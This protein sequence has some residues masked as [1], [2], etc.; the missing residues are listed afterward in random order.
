VYLALTIFAP[1]SCR[2]KSVRRS[3]RLC[4]L[5]RNSEWFRNLEQSSTVIVCTSTDP[6]LKTLAFSDQQASENISLMA[7]KLSG[8]CNSA[9]T[10]IPSE[11]NKPLSV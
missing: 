9:D 2:E 3:N 6:T 8:A 11:A 5:S 4:S 10:M 1:Y 7:T